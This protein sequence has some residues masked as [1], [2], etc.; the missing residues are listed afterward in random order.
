MMQ[1]QRVEQHDRGN[2][3]HDRAGSGEMKASSPGRQTKRCCS[4]LLR[5]VPL[6]VYCILK[7]STSLYGFQYLIGVA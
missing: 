5:Y 1:I 4:L 6:E 2:Q 3:A 7:K